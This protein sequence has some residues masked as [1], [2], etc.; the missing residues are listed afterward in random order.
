MKFFIN[1]GFL[2]IK[3]FVLFWKQKIIKK[4]CMQDLL[5]NQDFLVSFW[6]SYSLLFQFSFLEYY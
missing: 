2:N 3:T 5:S 6:N 1:R 4:A